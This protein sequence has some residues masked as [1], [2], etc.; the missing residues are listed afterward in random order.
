MTSPQFMT[1]S[2]FKHGVAIG[3]CLTVLLAINPPAEAEIFIVGENGSIQDAID[4][5]VA[6]PEHDQIRVQSRT[7]LVENLDIPLDATTGNL[8]ISGGWNSSCTVQDRDPSL[9]VID[10]NMGRVVFA[11]VH[12][13]A[14][15]TVANLTIRDGEAGAFGGG[16]AILASDSEVFVYDVWFLDNTSESTGG[17]AAGGG[18][19]LQFTDAYAEVNNNRFVHNMMHIPDSAPS[20]VGGSGGGFKATLHGSQLEF[21]DNVM[22]GN[23]CTRIDPTG[24]ASGCSVHVEAYD[25]STIDITQNTVINTVVNGFDSINGIAGYVKCGTDSTGL[26]ERNH[27]RAATVSSAADFAPL[28]RTSSSA[29]A[30]LRQRSSLVA[31]GPGS[32]L[33]TSSHLSTWHGVNL[34]VVDNGGHGIWLNDTS[35]GTSSLTLYN[36]VSHGNGG[37]AVFLDTDTTLVQGANLLDVD[38]N[39]VNA[40]GGYYQLRRGSLAL[41]AGVESPPGELS[42]RDLDGLPR[43]QG[44]TVDIGAYEGT[45]MIFADR[46]ETGD[47]ACWSDG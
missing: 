11:Q 33:V 16:M 17:S 9:T 46:F 44:S 47:T 21:A 1:W 3:I 13:G 42:G 6:T 10:G 26:M 7:L 15:F 32:G 37:D 19:Y 28:L 41:E 36:S 12:G 40:P 23:G 29:N 43:I 35:A 34:S 20:Y 8:S 14:V 39:F 38:P 18:L 27:W 5:A 45:T 24:N 31:S 30:T 4:L 22:D 25:G 2:G